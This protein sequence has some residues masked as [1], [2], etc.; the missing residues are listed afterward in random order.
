[1]TLE[2][3]CVYCGSNAGRQ[4]VYA[5]QAKAFGR[6]LAQR[7]LGLIYGGSSAGI[8]GVVADAVLAH[9][10]RAIGIIPEVLVKK[11]LA[12]KGLTELHVVGSMHE[13]KTLMAEKADGF[14][15]LPGGV[16]TF[17]EIFETWTWAQLGLHSKPCGLLNIAGYYDK[18]AAF[19]DHTVEEAF[20]RPQH[21]AML[22]VEN[23]A[24]ALLDRFAAYE[25][26][27]VTKWISPESK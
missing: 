26:P 12:H 4:P 19:L 14:V 27:T 15:A 21:R 8:M 5:E 7:G 11:E 3:I 22:V 6:T 13:R 24:D 25:A 17:E 23:D 16:G 2:N 18:L 10:G 1:M 9:G 20:M